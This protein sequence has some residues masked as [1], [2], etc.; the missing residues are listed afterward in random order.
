MTRNPELYLI[1]YDICGAGPEAVRRLRKVYRVLRGYGEH[2]Q[3]SVFRCTLSDRQ[4]AQLEGQLEEVIDHSRD[5]VMIVPL[6][7]ASTAASWRMYT[8]GVP[9]DAPERV[10]RVV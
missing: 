8:L 5:Q 7:A 9:F 10:V 1:C 6:G 4:L 3:Y 2:L